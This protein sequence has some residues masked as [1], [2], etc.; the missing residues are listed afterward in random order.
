MYNESIL[1]QLLKVSELRAIANCFKTLQCVFNG[2]LLLSW[3]RFSL[4]NQMINCN[5]F[6]DTSF[7]KLVR[8]L[9]RCSETEVMLFMIYES[10]NDDLEFSY[11]YKV[12]RNLY[13]IYDIC[14]WI[15]TTMHLLKKQNF[16]LNWHIKHLLAMAYN[17]YPK[18]SF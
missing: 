4:R 18:V 7:K 11:S 13:T 17:T 9:L 12:A 10:I 15:P 14:N 1:K 2:H 8:Q 5:L 3:Y 16:K 6:L